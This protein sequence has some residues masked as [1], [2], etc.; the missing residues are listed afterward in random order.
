M[1]KRC[2]YCYK[3]LDAEVDFH[4]SCS[5][6][7]FGSSEP[8]ALDYTLDE[9]AELAK[10]VVQSSVTVPGVQPKLSLGYIKDVLQD[11]GKER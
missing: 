6:R 1:S 3:E 8:P 4:T 10:E 2:L 5:S 9:M 11:G 7:F